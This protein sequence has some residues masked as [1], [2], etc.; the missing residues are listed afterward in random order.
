MKK[1]LAITGMM[2]LMFTA[3]GFTTKVS[4]QSETTV[5]VTAD[6]V[7]SY[8]WRGV[9][10]TNTPNFQ[11][12][13]ALVK[14]GLEIGV[15]GSTDYSGTYK[16]ADIYATYTVGSFKVGLTDYN[17]NF[18]GRYFD[19]DKKTTDHVLEGSLSYLGTTELPLSISVNT[20]FY[21]ADK[22]YDKDLA[23][24][25]PSK[26]AYSTYVEL[27]YTFS[28]FSVFAGVT[29]GDGYYG[30]GY[31]GVEGVNLVNLGVSSSKNI[32]ITDSYSLPIKAT[33]GFNPQKED[34]YLVFGITF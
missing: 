20:M 7:S 12:T 18:K 26:N 25:D 30:D 15:W 4:A 24:Q 8:V 11:P 2:L 32:K 6:L 17:W 23:A 16:E 28:Q 3:A 5:K 34:A 21:G 27:G 14:G 31:G 29:P 13:L 1:S 9:T 19:F 33:F 10:S 22:K